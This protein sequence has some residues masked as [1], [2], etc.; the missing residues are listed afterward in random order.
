MQDGAAAHAR[1]CGRAQASHLLGVFTLLF[2]GWY[3]VLLLT[4]ESSMDQT[5][6]Y[7]VNLLINEFRLLNFVYFTFCFW[8]CDFFSV[9]YTHMRV[10]FIH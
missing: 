6:E 8:L 5:S 10:V 9:I 4:A 7:S 1:T 3:L 2:F